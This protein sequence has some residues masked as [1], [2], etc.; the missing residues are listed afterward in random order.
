M[1]EHSIQLI[2]CDAGGT[3]TDIFLVDDKG[4]FVIGKAATTPRDE[5]VGFWESLTDAFEQWDID[6]NK[7]AKEI[8]PGVATIV[9]CGT[10]MLNALLTRTGRKTGVIITKGLEDSMLHQRGAEI[11]AG[12]G[13]QDKI[14]KVAHIHPSPLVPKKLIRGVTE[15]TTIFGEELI[16]LYEHEVREAVASLLDED[17][18]TICILFLHSYF[19]SRHEKRAGEIAQE[20]MK[21]KGKN[22]DLYLSC[23][24][25]PVWRESS[26]L[27]ALVL[28][29]YGSEVGRRHLLRVDKKVRDNGFRYPLQTMLG[30]GGIANVRYRRLFKACFSGP[31]G[32]LLGARYL[33]QEMDMPNLVCSDMGGTSFDVGLIMGGEP[34]MLREVE[35]A[36]AYMN[37]PTLVMD[38]IGAGA[39]QMLTVNPAS[40]RVDIGPGAAGSDPGPVSYNRGNKIPTVMDCCL[41]LGII[42]PDYYL[43]GK[44]KVYP[45]L[46]LAAIKEK[47]SGPLGIDPYDFAEGVIKLINVRMKE[48]I[49][50][51]LSVRGYSPINYYCIGYG[52]AGPLF[53]AGYT[54]GLP[55]KGVFTVPWAAAFSAFGC[56]AAD[57]VHRYQQTTQVAIPP[58]ANEAMKMVVAKKIN[59]VWEEMEKVAL[60]EAREE[61]LNESE[62][63]INPIAYLRYTRQ[64]EDVETI[65]PVHR[66]NSAQ[67]V[68]KLV[69]AFEQAYAKKY[70]YSAMFPEVGYEM[71]EL[72]LM[73]VAPKAKPHIPKLP[74]SGKTPSSEA[75]NGERKMYADGKWNNTK[76][77]ELDKLKPGN[78]VEGYAVLE[79]SSTTMPIPAGY[80]VVIDEYRRFWIRE[81]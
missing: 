63:T 13:Y 33:S 49:K 39:G 32:G 20:V 16:P 9:Y 71:M 18:E 54:E 55:F 37:V 46:A 4:D 73:V 17:V 56:T 7:Q 45:E 22:V 1:E 81:V 19:D 79:A 35:V 40:R 76:L 23:E 28:Q 57:Y 11:H 50:T 44:L 43:G 51:V 52:G 6:W 15:R 53:L 38:S 26:R 74:L 60:E 27:N 34:I 69:A 14:H 72:G 77:Y 66:L 31:I 29:A 10:V 5:S 42:N 41:I 30:D 62:L 61:G 78:E 67:D 8:L 64:L 21:E 58:K 59:K 3:M 68:D 25:A 80:K 75:Y 2:G 12:Y 48:H 70:A 36:R 47:C 65:S 24:I